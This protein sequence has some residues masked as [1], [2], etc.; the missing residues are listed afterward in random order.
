MAFTKALY[1]PWIDVRDET[2]LKNTMLYWEKIQTIVPASIKQPYS[3]KTAQEFYSEGLLEPFYVKSDM[4]D[5][6]ELTDDV[7]KYLESPEGAEVI[8]SKE[9]SEY[10]HI[11]L[12]KLPGEIKELVRIHP[13]KLP[14]EIKSRITS[15]FEGAW[16]HVDSR[17]ADFYMTLLASRLSEKI[18]GGLLTD[19]AMYNK[20][21]T[22]AR[23]DANLSL[24]NIPHLLTQGTLADLILERVTIDPNTP[25]EK[26]LD[27]RKEYSNELGRFR[28]KID[29]LTNTVSSDQSSDALRQ[30]IKDIHINEVQPAIASLKEGLNDVKIKWATDNL[31]KVSFF[32]ESATSIPLAL[33]GLSVP[34]ALFAGIGV[35]LTASTILYN[36]EKAKTLRENPFSY[37]LAAESTFNKYKSESTINKFKRILRLD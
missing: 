22:A 16:M 3:T 4:K 12:D 36:H 34:Q 9:I 2:W 14:H 24:R 7:L 6:D 19:N 5:I 8:L 17:F 20:L 18:G 32:S 37:V 10:R 23:L 35:S 11:H 15:R 21:A 31:L 27:F 30:K 25:V 1:Y 33:L 13:D 29:E 26:I 28:T